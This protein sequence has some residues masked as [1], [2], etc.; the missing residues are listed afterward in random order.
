M[1]ETREVG[2]AKIYKLNKKN[3]IIEKFIELDDAIS[4]HYTPLVEKK[5]W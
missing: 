3:S 1:I 5:C 2:R 4:D